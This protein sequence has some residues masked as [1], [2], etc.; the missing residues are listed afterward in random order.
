MSSDDSAAAAL[1]MA[2]LQLERSEAAARAKGGFTAI[3]EVGSV[4]LDEL[5]SVEVLSAERALE[6]RT[7]AR[8]MLSTP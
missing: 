5:L 8:Q 7:R 1:F 3:E 4:S 6:A 2:M